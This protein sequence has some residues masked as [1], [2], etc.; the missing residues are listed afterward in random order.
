MHLFVKFAK[1]KKYVK[2]FFL[3]GLKKV[4]FNMITIKV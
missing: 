2:K 4:S 1:V 3:G